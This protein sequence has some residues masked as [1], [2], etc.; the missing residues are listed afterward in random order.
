MLEGLAGNRS[1]SSKCGTLKRLIYE[2][3]DAINKDMV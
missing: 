2:D 3:I 1:W